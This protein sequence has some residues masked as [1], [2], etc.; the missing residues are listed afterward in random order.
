MPASAT[1]LGT[2][3][4]ANPGSVTQVSSTGGVTHSVLKTMSHEEARAPTSH[5]L[6]GSSLNIQGSVVT[7]LNFSIVY[8]PGEVAQVTY[9]YGQAVASDSPEVQNG[10]LA[11]PG[12]LPSSVT[13]FF[14]LDAS[15]EQ[16]SILRHPRYEDLSESD[17]Q[18][19]AA[20]LQMGVLDA[21][22]IARR[23]S[24]STSERAQEC[25][26]KIES[27]VTSY[28]APKWIWRYRKLNT[29][30]SVSGNLGKISNPY[31]PAPNIGGNWLFTGVTGNGWDGGALELT[32]TWESSPEGDT[33]DVDLY[34]P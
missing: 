16:K 9:N 6:L 21:E 17:K 13:E 8:D 19:L 26:D 33:W 34:N 5:P 22:S 20:M 25:A 15:M 18:V 7:L 12:R 27:G 29:N 4:T 1:H 32:A 31:G 11:Y 2:I 14:E 10:N 30:W 24:L 28:L 23:E 3:T